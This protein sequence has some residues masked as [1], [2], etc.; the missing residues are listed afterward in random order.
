MMQAAQASDRRDLKSAIALWQ[1]VLARHPTHAPA[2]HCLGDAAFSTGTF[3]VA[4]GLQRRALATDAR[5]VPAMISLSRVLS[6]NRR[7]TEALDSAKR[8][9]VLDGRN[10]KALVRLGEAQL[11]AGDTA[12][13]HASFRRALKLAPNHA[14]AAHMVSAL[15]GTA[16]ASPIRYAAEVFDSYAPHFEEHLVQRLGY[17][18]PN[19]LAALLRKT[20]PQRQFT[21]AIDLGCGTGLM[22]DALQGIATAIDGIDI[23]PKMIE[24]AGERGLYREVAT[25]EITDFLARATDASY[26]LAVAADV[27]IYVGRLEPTLA[28]LARVL[29]PGGVFAFSV[30]HADAGDVSIRSSGRFAHSTHYVEK[31]AADAGLAVRANVPTVLRKD[32]EHPVDGRLV[33]LERR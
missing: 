1:R 12:S 14:L 23:A 8:A 6:A 20:W 19:D 5:F 32:L 3:D 16:D 25:A 30:E 29:P 17:G 33:I 26:E 4:E 27:F 21:A 31:S 28:E 13:A 15:S 2:L 10:V 11:E 9:A 24:L 18:V 22:A 7:F